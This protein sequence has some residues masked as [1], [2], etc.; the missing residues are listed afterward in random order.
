M[1][2]FPLFV[3]KNDTFAQRQYQV[4]AATGPCQ[5]DL[6]FIYEVDGE[7]RCLGD[8]SL[9]T[10]VVLPLESQLPIQSHEVDPNVIDNWFVADLVGS[11]AWSN[12]AALQQARESLHEEIFECHGIELSDM[13]TALKHVCT[14][15]SE[16]SH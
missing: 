16:L 14:R 5:L 7:E 12:L 15:I 3:P 9:Y 13:R 4:D 6:F 11:G 8:A 10:S 1:T 2:P